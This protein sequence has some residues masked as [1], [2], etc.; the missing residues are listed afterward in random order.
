M[1]LLSCEAVTVRLGGVIALD[2][3]GLTVAPSECVGLVGPNGAGKTTLLNVLTGF[4]KPDQG[5]VVLDDSE[6]TRWSVRQRARAGLSRTFQAQH[7]F[8]AV[9]VRECLELTALCTGRRRREAVADADDYIE[10]LGLAAS[11]RKPCGELPHGDAQRVSLARAL[12]VRPRYVVLDEP[13]AGLSEGESGDFAQAIRQTA[14]H[15]VGVLLVEHDLSFVEQVCGRLYAL[16][17]GRVIFGG[18][19]REAFA[20]R[21]VQEAY[22]GTPDD[23]TPD[24][25]DRLDLSPPDQHDD[26][27][28]G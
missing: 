10:L 11:E 28:H 18:S 16:T 15:G 19:I 14:E 17:E 24:H 22:L 13:A 5:R 25:D 7:L 23:D 2:D 21:I 12:I 4:I 9:S 6:V 3:V 8:G 27:A 26:I 20:S 1:G